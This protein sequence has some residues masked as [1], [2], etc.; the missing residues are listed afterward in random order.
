MLNNRRK[1]NSIYISISLIRLLLWA[2][3]CVVR[4]FLYAIIMCSGFISIYCKNI[5]L[6][7]AISAI[8]NRGMRFRD[9]IPTTQQK[10][11]ISQHS[12]CNLSVF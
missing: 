4:E 12:F 5:L 8:N 1:V 3:V 2:S 11:Q 7:L 10:I 9:Y 6:H